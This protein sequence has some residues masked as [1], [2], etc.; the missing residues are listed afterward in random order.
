MEALLWASI[1]VLDDAVCE[2]SL[3][4]RG[5]S[6]LQCVAVA[7]AERMKL[8]GL[9]DLFSGSMTIIF[10]ALYYKAKSYHFHRNMAFAVRSSR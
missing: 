3:T 4:S 1:I 7:R 8:P 6:H 10:Q 2:V 5:S 9:F